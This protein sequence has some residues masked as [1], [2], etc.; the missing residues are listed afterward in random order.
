MVPIKY[1]HLV[2]ID[3]IAEYG[4]CESMGEL[5]LSEPAIH[6]ALP[7]LNANLHLADHAEALDLLE[8]CASLFSTGPHDFGLLKGTSYQ[9]KIDDTRSFFSQLYQK[10]RVEEAHVSIKLNKLLDVGLLQTS[11]SPWVSPLILLNKKN[12]GHWSLWIIAALMCSPRRI[13]IPI[14]ELMTHFGY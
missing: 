5:R 12:W 2:S 4:P 8:E 9:L 1:V 11:K 10:Y 7:P 14:L 3:D 13:A 6:V